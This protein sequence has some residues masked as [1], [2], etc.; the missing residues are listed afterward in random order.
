MS[1]RPQLLFV[2]PRFL[3]PADSGGKIRSAQILRGIKDGE[4][5]ITLAAPA[6]ADG[7]Q[8]FSAE[9]DEV[10]DRFVHWPAPAGGLVFAARRAG[11]LLSRLPVSVASDRSP[12]ARAVVARELARGPDVAVFDFAHSTVLAAA[13]MGVPSVMFTHNVE[14]EI[15]A[16]HARVARHWLMRRVWAAQHAKMERFERAALARFDRIVAVSER[17]AAYFRDRW[18]LKGVAVIPTGVDLEFFRYQAPPS[19]LQVVFTGSMDW[20]AN[21]D[22]IE[23]MLDAVWP[24]VTARVPQATFTVVGRNPPA[25]L[26]A[27]ARER[28]V[29]WEF[30]GFV[31]DVRPWVYAA[32]VYVIP[33]R[34]GGGTRIKAFEAMAMGCPV[35]STAIGVEGLPVE[36]GRHYRRADT[37]TA[38]AD[39]VVALLENAEE[40]LRLSTAARRHV[41]ENFSYRRAAE[42][43]AA[44]CRD[45]MRA[46]RGDSAIARTEPVSRRE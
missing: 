10:C 4:F 36:G 1:R 16:R 27:K 24:L 40:R 41:E 26:I 17:D 30:T 37:A 25:S 15:F 8:G 28:G 2:S 22:G 6:P 34:V 31:A 14:S 7:A 43:F 23:F 38:F 46:R 12:E 44:I 18:Q 5:A 21:I 33:L 13:Q 29:H 42:C 45:A 11:H 32:S 20:A 3:F 35:V 9:L 19:T 39:A